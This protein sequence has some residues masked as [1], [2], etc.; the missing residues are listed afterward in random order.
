MANNSALRGGA[1]GADGTILFSASLGPLS[2]VAASG[3]DPV[4]VTRLD[5]PRQS[6]HVF[7][8]FLP[9][10]RHFLF[11]VVGTPEASGIYLGSLDGREP[12]RL[13]AADSTGAY[14]APGMI[15][16]ARQTTLM[17]QRLDLNQVELTGDPMRLADPVGSNGVVG[18][19]GFSISADG[20]VAYRS[21]GGSVRQLKWYDRTGKAVGLVGQPDSSALQYP[22]LSPDGTHVAVSRTVQ[23]NADVWLVDLVRGGVT[24]F[25]FDPAVDIAQ[26][27]CEIGEWRKR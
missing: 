6:Q 1:W 14:L 15:A 23:N 22:Q 8:Q 9:D 4:T 25:T 26:F 21:G 2:R 12:K 7:P 19:G 3:G 20:R 11:Y 18:F 5:P 13:V 27:V 17:A 16:F 24:R 10:G